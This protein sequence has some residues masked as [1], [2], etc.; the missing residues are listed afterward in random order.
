M[1]RLFDRAFVTVKRPPPSGMGL[2]S[3]VAQNVPMKITRINEAPA[4]LSMDEDWGSQMW[5]YAQFLATVD[6][7]QGDA[8]EGYDSPYLKATTAASRFRV[9]Q[10][11]DH[12]RFP[13]P[14]I[15]AYLISTQTA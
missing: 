2:E 13:R 1:P 5:F 14:R 15:A 12:H 11:S 7:R 6:L 4:G 10:V 3:V 8:V 9:V